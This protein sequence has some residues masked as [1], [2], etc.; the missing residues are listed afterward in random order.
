V[1]RNKTNVFELGAVNALTRHSK[2]ELVSLKFL[3]NAARPKVN[4]NGTIKK[5][6]E[7]FLSVEKVVITKLPTSFIPSGRF[8]RG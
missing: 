8:G 3:E 2:H 7:W 1:Q 6:P 5:W 4:S